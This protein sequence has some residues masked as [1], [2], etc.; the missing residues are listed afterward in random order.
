MHELLNKILSCLSLDNS[1]NLVYN[2]SIVI[3]SFDDT[4]N[5]ALN[6]I[7]LTNFL[8]H[9]FYSKQ[10]EIYYININEIQLANDNLFETQLSKIHPNVKFESSE[11]V[12]TNIINDFILQVSKNNI[13]LTIDVNQNVAKSKI[14]S[15]FSIGDK[16]VVLFS[17]H[18]PNISNGFYVYK[19]QVK[20]LNFDDPIG[21]LYFNLNPSH[22][23]SFT[24]ILLDVSY[25]NSFVF[26]YK[27]FKNIQNQYRTDSAVFYF[28][29]KDFKK[30][31]SILFPRIFQENYFNDEVSEF[32]FKI[33]KGVGFAEEPDKPVTLESFG[34]NRCRKLAEC[35]YGSF[36]NKIEITLPILI[37]KL[38][39]ENIEI[40]EIYK[41]PKS[42]FQPVEYKLKF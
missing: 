24:E 14:S 11:W 36:E 33:F 2:K 13:T 31:E 3:L 23:I 34:L 42:K 37:K 39:S 5:K 18:F 30:I 6:I 35:L 27:I 38:S 32:H 41:N 40:N 12:I 7:K 17:C 21:R 9:F 8:Y 22:A 26:D 1:G 25:S 28:K 10:S 4:Q 16:L 29:L 20:E 19:S 15:K